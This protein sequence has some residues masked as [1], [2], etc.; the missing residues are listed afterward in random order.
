MVIAAKIFYRNAVISGQERST[1]FQNFQNPNFIDLPQSIRDKQ[2]KRTKTYREIFL[3]EMQDYNEL[4]EP[5]RKALSDYFK[6]DLTNKQQISALQ[7]R[8]F[9]T[10][11]YFL[12]IGLETNFAILMSARNWSENI[13]FLR[14]SR[15][16]LERELA[17]IIYDLL[18]GTIKELTDKGYIPEADGLIRHTEA[19][20]YNFK[21]TQKILELLPDINRIAPMR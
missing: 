20:T 8:T 9:D 7:A 6:P 14:A 18:S 19:N 15:F 4:L 1:R 2:S 5:T 16:S 17:D 11:R 10:V 21:S 13:A 3:K 12:P